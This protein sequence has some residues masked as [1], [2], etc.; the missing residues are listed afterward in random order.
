MT[1][2]FGV[3][4]NRVHIHLKPNSR[5]GIVTVGGGGG[6]RVRLKPQKEVRI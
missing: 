5:C 6:G 1:I 4:A 3:A 2:L